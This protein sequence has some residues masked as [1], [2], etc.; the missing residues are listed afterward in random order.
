MTAYQQDNDAL[1]VKLLQSDTELQNALGALREDLATTKKEA[2]TSLTQGSAGGPPR[3]PIWWP[4]SLAEQHQQE[5][6][7]QLLSEELGKVKETTDESDGDGW[8]ASP[9]DVGTRLRRT[10]VPV[11]TEVGSVR[12]DDGIG[13]NQ[14]RSHQEQNCSACARTSVSMSGLVAT[15][16]KEIQDPARSGR[17]EYLRIHPVEILRACRRW[18]MFKV[19]LRKTDVKRNRYT[20]DVLADDKRVEKKDKRYERA[21]AVLL[22]RRPPALRNGDQPG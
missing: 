22:F 6:A 5:Q 16:G 9:T 21:R 8:T 2:N 13:Q 3:T 10:S 1:R 14:H 11:A 7:N 4:E 19:A 18:A 12:S 15:N 20:V 17:P